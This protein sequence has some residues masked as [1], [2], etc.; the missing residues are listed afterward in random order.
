MSDIFEKNLN[1]ELNKLNIFHNSFIR[2]TLIQPMKD[3]FLQ[4]E[5]DPS[6]TYL[7]ENNLDLPILEILRCLYIH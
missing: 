7:V 4:N 2:M 1:V 3:N 6:K 5:L